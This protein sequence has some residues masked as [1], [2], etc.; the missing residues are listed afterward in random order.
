MCL[1]R[2]LADRCQSRAAMGRTS[3]DPMQS[4]T[5]QYRKGAATYSFADLEGLLVGVTGLQRRRRLPS[6]S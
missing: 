3:H 5:T 4:L 2:H 1:V 6:P